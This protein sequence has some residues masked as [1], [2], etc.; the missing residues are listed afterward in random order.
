[1]IVPVDSFV[2]PALQGIQSAG[3]ADKVKVVLRRARTSPACS[4][5]KDGQQAGDLGTPVIYEGW[6]FANAL[7]QLLA[8][9][10]G[11][12]GRRTSS[13]ATS[14]PPTSASSPSTPRSYLTADWFGDDALQADV[15][16]RLGRQ[17]AMTDRPMQAGGPQRLQD[18]R[19]DHG[20]RDADLAVAA[21]RDPRPRR[22]ER[23][24][25]SRRS[26]RSSRATTRR[27]PVRRSRW[28]GRSSSCPSSGARP[29]P[30]G[31]RSSTRTSACSTS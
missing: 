11:Q 27:T 9:D 15:P 26:S 25:A 30:P 22:P 3:F 28:T 2:P 6:K 18:V 7:V 17:V 10:A 23:L 31:S 24:R 4:A 13:P 16:H 12:Q 8:G 21:G 19:L 29:R 1:M 20:A 14:P 5:V